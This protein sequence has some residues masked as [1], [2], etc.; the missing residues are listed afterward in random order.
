MNVNT[1]VD[2]NQ[3]I[4]Q[5]QN[6]PAVLIAVLICL[7][8]AVVLCVL[9]IVGRWKTVKKLGGHGW[10]QIIPVYADWE[11][12]SKAGCEKALC[13]AFTVL[14]G[15]TLVSNVVKNETLQAIAGLCGLATFVIGIMVA[16]KVACRFGKGKGFTVGLV[17]LPTI[18]FAILGLGSA[19]A[20]DSEE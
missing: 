17:I 3:L 9:H 12:S 1:N 10:S 4:D 8:I 20:T 19:Q 14:S 15:I 11:M 13:I 18:F 16:Y 7:L 5:M 2:V 6:E